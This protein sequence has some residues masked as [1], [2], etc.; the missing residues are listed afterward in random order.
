MDSTLRMGVRG[1]R[2]DDDVVTGSQPAHLP[3]LGNT[4]T[5][6]LWADA[7]PAIVLRGI[8]HGGPKRI[9]PTADID[10][11]LVCVLL[12]LGCWASRDRRADRIRAAD[13][14]SV[15][16][17][18]PQSARLA[19]PTCV[20]DNF[21]RGSVM[22]LS[23]SGVGSCA[24]QQERGGFQDERSPEHPHDRDRPGGASGEANSA[25]LDAAASHICGSTDGVARRWS[26]R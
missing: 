26:R 7:L 13:G 2:A 14:C 18:L 9:G 21:S 6:Q 17:L 12:S 5:P 10:Q 4:S 15:V 8:R 23:P 16:S 20:A 25:A 22:F 11:T 19:S 3:L 1:K 24:W